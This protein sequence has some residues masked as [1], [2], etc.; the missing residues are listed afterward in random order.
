[1]RYAYTQKRSSYK[2][3]EAHERRPAYLKRDL[4]KETY[5]HVK[6]THEK[7]HV[8]MKETSEMRPV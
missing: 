7:I 5:I 3:K 2:Y 1:L 4:S 8:A 6:E